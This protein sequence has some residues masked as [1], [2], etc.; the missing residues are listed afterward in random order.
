MRLLAALILALASLP[1]APRT[2]DVTATDDMKFNVSSMTARPGEPIRIH[3][4]CCSAFAPT[5]TGSA[6]AK[7]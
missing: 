6:D 7:R 5:S 3:N 4:Q 2:I 1:T